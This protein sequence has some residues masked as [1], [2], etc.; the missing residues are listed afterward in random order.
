MTRSRFFIRL[1]AL[2][3]GFCGELAMVQA[4]VPPLGDTNTAR[5]W[6]V[7]DQALPL[8]YNIGGTDFNST[9]F[10]SANGTLSEQ[11]WI[12]RK[13]QA[14]RAVADKELFNAAPPLEYSSNRLIGR[15]AWNTRWK[16]VIPAVNLLN[17]EQTALSRFVGS[18]TDVQLYLRTY[19]HSGN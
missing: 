2:A 15:S 17:D 6:T 11:P 9:Q 10:F 3:L 14:F 16:I 4:A 18:V 8:P 1:I 13:H 12:I 19:S 7:Q 5:T